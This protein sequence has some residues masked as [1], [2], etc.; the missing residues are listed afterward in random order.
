MKLVVIFVTLAAAY[1]ELS[2]VCK[3]EIQTFKTCIT[4]A[5]GGVEDETQAELEATKEKVAE[6]YTKRG[7]EAPEE[8]EDHKRES[9]P[10]CLNV[11]EEQIKPKLETCTGFEL[12]DQKSSRFAG[13]GN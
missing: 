8:K 5:K 7:C 9:A 2:E 3:K 11:Y 4:A 6:C 13:H 1:A 10:D 12:P